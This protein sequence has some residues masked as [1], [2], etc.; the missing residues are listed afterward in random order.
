VSNIISETEHYR[1]NWPQHANRILNKA[2]ECKLLGWRGTEHR[3]TRYG[4][5]PHQEDL[6]IHSEAQSWLVH[7]DDGHIIRRYVRSSPYLLFGASSILL[8]RKR[9][10]CLFGNPTDLLSPLLEMFLASSIQPSRSKCVSLE[11]HF[12]TTLHT[13]PQSPNSPL[14]SFM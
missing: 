13:A 14:T 2:L 5:Q 7:D 6:E 12:N 8:H 9:T 10:K 3:K 1:N 11:I 4:H